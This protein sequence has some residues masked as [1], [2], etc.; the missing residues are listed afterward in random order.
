MPADIDKGTILVLSAT[1][2]Q[3]GAVARELLHGGQPVRAL[4]R[5]P[6]SAKAQALA[7]PGSFSTISVMAAAS[8]QPNSPLARAL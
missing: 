5:D 2:N 3:G 6:Q 7:A 4:T 1:G 8:R